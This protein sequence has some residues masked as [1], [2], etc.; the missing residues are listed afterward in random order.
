MGFAA[1]ALKNL[2]ASAPRPRYAGHFEAFH[3]GVIARQAM[4]WIS[5][6]FALV[7]LA[8]IS[9]PE[10]LAADYENGLAP[11]GAP[12]SAFPTPSR[13]VAGIVTDIWRDEESRDRASEAENVMNLLG[14]N[15]GFAVA[16]IGAGSGYYT[17]RLA[18][19]VGPSGHVYADDIVPDYLARLARR[20]ASEGL[21][22]SI[23]IVRGEPHDPRLPAASVDLALL[24]H[25]YH[26]VAQ[27]YGL[28]WNLRPALRPG[29]RVAVIDA[30]KRI[31]RGWVSPD[32]LL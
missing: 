18:R 6:Y 13:P 5:P 19:R 32:G 23:T 9:A 30:R 7:L 28:L 20:V 25:M 14:V 12:P 26:E 21:G 2:K 17:V 3:G 15:S 4:S 27:P 8:L 31:G 16:D 10:I 11:P 24:V 29:G 22:G 1:S